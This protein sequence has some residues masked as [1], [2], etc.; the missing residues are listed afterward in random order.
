MITGVGSVAILVRDAKKSA[1]WYHDMLDFEIVGNE[2]HAVFVRPKGG[3]SPLLHLCGP[4]EAWE[5]DHPGGRTGVW[6]HCG[7][8]RMRR[9]EASGLLLPASHAAEVERTY[10][11]LKRRGVEFAEE[12]TATDWGK[13][14]LLKDP[15]GNVF[16]IS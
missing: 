8:I 6:L 3:H 16:E 9:D 15:D 1:A 14:A 12:L 10:R 7:E 2:G 13:Y 5:S 4:N 11:E